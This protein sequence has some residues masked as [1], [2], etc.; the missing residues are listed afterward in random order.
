MLVVIRQCLMVR[1]MIMS[2]FSVSELAICVIAID[3]DLFLSHPVVTGT[4][5]MV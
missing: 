3:N 4:I 1:Y 5:C 2:Q